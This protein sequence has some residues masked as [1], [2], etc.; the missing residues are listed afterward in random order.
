MYIKIFYN[1]IF[2]VFILLTW[3][4]SYESILNNVG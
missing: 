1:Y 4:K 3:Q 2:L